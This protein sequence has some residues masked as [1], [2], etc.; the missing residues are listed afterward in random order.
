MLFI[1]EP[2]LQLL[3]SFI[4]YTYQLNYFSSFLPFLV[5]YPR[6]YS[7]VQGYKMLLFILKVSHLAVT[8]RS[9]SSC[10]LNVY[11]A[12]LW[13][14]PHFVAFKSIE[15]KCKVMCFFSF[16]LK[17]V[18]NLIPL[19]H[20]PDRCGLLKVRETLTSFSFKIVVL[21][22]CPRISM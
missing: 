10:E 11:S 18:P 13:I 1:T 12:G 21:I 19:L 15:Q 9:E 5:L 3:K 8:L 4:F 7:L 16:P 14:H 22:L 17:C 2:P 20:C 6:N